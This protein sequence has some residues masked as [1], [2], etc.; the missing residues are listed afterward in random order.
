MFAIAVFREGV[1]HLM[2]RKD[3]ILYSYFSEGLES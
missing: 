1:D 2:K 3:I